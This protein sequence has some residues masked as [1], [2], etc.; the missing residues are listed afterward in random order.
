M[1]RALVL[2]MCLVVAACAAPPQVRLGSST[3]GPEQR[4]VVLPTWERHGYRNPAT[5]T[6]LTQI[7]AVGADWVQIVPTWYQPSSSAN[8][9]AP[10]DSSVDDDDLRAVVELA[11]DKGLKVLLKPHVDVTGGTDRGKISPADLDRWFASYRAFITRYAALAAELGVEQFAVGTELSGVSGERDRW[12]AIIADVRAAYRGPLV[13]AAHHNEYPKVAFWDAVDVIG[14]DVYW[15]LSAEPTADVA[16]LKRAYAA[17]RDALAAFAARYD[18]QILFT[19][20][21]FPSQRGAATAPWNGQLSDQPAQDEQAAAAQALL[22]TFTGQP[23]WAG[24]FWWTWAVVHRHDVDTPRA[25]DHSVQGK[26]TEDVLRQWW[27]QR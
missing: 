18:R 10:T 8:V 22:A 3:L 11:H 5:D 1:R 25:L 27:E 17:R 2:V 23:W 26:L 15:P 21:G 19:E 16:V 4:G 20:A 12:L 14:I 6:A 7:A 9:I 24:V 13:Y